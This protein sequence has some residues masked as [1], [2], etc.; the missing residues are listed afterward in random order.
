MS[1]K[2]EIIADSLSPQKDRLTTFLVTYPRIIHAEMCRHRMFSRNTASSRAIPFKKMAKDVEENPF[3]PIAWQKAH[4]GMQGTEYITDSFWVELNTRNWLKA[5]D[6]AV[7]QAKKLNLDIDGNY[8]VTKQ[9][10]NRL[11]EPFMWTTEI[12][13]GTEW[14]NFFKLRCPQYEYKGEFFRSK[15]ECIDSYKF[16]HGE[17]FKEHREYL[18]SL[19][20]LEWLQINKSQADIHIQAIAELM[21]DAYNESTPKQLK[22]GEWHI[23]YGDNIDDGSLREWFWLEYKN[24]DPAYGEYEREKIRIATARAARLSYTT[25]GDN[26]KIDYKAD[27]KLHDRLLEQKHMSPFEHCTKAMS[28][29]EYASY[30]KGKLMVDSD[31]GYYTIEGPSMDEKLEGGWCRNFKGFIQYRHLIENQ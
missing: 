6:Y 18:K 28:D 17:S 4:K 2:C 8:N 29:E 25:L 11:L 24:A 7:Q 9:L 13:S 5:K 14:E 3:M 20:D 30:V 16:D 22:T 31:D 12:I 10:C 23:P 26:P 15:K 27:I 1:F 19:S 21:W